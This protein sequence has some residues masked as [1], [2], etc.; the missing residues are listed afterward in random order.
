[1]TCLS[2]CAKFGIEPFHGKVLGYHGGCAQVLVPNMQEE[3]DVSCVCS[4]VRL[5]ARDHCVVDVWGCP[6]GHHV[7]KCPARAKGMADADAGS[8]V[9]ERTCEESC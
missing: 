6:A 3:L 1:M 9:L 7:M 5:A 8:A 2:Y 4:S